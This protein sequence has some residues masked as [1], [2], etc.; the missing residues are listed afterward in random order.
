MYTTKLGSSAKGS[1][2]DIILNLK[3]HKLNKQPSMGTKHR[4][5]SYYQILKL[6]KLVHAEEYKEEG[7]C[8]HALLLDDILLVL[9]YKN[10]M[11]WSSLFLVFLTL[12]IFYSLD[13]FLTVTFLESFGEHSRCLIIFN[14][15]DAFRCFLI[16]YRFHNFWFGIKRQ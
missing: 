16:F 9:F 6:H 7:W 5:N 14:I 2:S 8:K 3:R 11:Q 4:L 15:L 13:S 12:V 10:G 1:S